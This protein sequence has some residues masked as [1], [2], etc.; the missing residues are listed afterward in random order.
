MKYRTSKIVFVGLVLFLIY[1][2]FH[3][4]KI[5]PDFFAEIVPLG[6]MHVL[7]CVAI[8]LPAVAFVCVA[9][10]MAKYVKS[11]QAANNKRKD[12]LKNFPIKSFT[13]AIGSL[14]VVLLL[15]DLAKTGARNVL[16]MS[17]DEVSADV[18][19]SVNGELV[20]N[21]GEM[22]AELKKVVPMRA[23]HTNITKK[24][25]LEILS[26]D[27]ILIVELGRDEGMPQEHWV[28]YPKY[29]WRLYSEVGRIVTDV[30]DDY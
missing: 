20:A 28:F 7:S 6:T 12:S 29:R 10:Y 25:R 3:P 13:F 2:G 11:G 22:V 5:A 16:K 19:V 21:P 14:A 26:N 4:A 1:A 30:F 9:V 24:L 17:L 15:S 27:N 18:A 23:H 8:V